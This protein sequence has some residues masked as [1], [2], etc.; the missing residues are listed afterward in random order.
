M[1]TQEKIDVGSIPVKITS[2]PKMTDEAI[3]KVEK[4]LDLLEQV[5]QLSAELNE[6][7]GIDLRV[8]VSLG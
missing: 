2:T 6:Y 8:R 5:K 1:S 4:L 7:L 3:P